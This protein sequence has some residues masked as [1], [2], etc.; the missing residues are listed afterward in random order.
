MKKNNKNISNSVPLLFETEGARRATGVS[1]NNS[2][3]NC[4]RSYS[5]LCSYV[6][7]QE[8][9]N[10]KSRWIRPA[11]LQIQPQRTQIKTIFALFVSLCENFVI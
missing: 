4:F 8:I 6:P 11:Q 9:G 3:R 10:K 5:F 2:E 1:N 7:K